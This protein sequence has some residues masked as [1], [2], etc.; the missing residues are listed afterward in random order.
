MPQLRAACSS[1]TKYHPDP[2]LRMGWQILKFARESSL[3]DEV[4]PIVKGKAAVFIAD[5]KLPKDDARTLYLE[6]AAVLP[7]SY[8]PLCLVHI[9]L[10]LPLSTLSILTSPPPPSLAPIPVPSACRQGSVRPPCD[11]PQVV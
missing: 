1:F 2:W 9:T 10:R 7:V 8:C 5:W 6:I 3:L 4:I 11:I